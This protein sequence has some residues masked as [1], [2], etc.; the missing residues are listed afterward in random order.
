MKENIPEIG[1]EY[2]F[3]D[4]GK[5][6]PSRC[7]KAKVLRVI[8]GN[9]DMI[10]E[11]PDSE[12]DKMIPVS[13]QDIHKREVDE[14]RQSE[15]FIICNSRGAKPIPGEPWLYSEK[16]DFFVE[17]EIP[18]YDENTIWFVRTIDGGWFSLNIQSSWQA[19]VL[20]VEGSVYENAKNYY[21]WY[22]SEL[23]EKGELIEYFSGNDNQTTSPNPIGL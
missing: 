13:L 8:P 6:S 7:Y 12:T 3:F 18:G 23:K 16:T 11:I 5:I 14:H 19:G 15:S 20:D 22:D 17:C 10:L 4:D 9:T 1:K 2:Y 21:T